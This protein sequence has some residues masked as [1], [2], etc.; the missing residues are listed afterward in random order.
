MRQKAEAQSK[1]LLLPGY[2]LPSVWRIFPLGRSPLLCYL[3][4]IRFIRICKT[5]QILQRRLLQRRRR[6]SH[7]G[8]GFNYRSKVFQR[9]IYLN[10]RPLFQAHLLTSMNWDTILRFGNY[11]TNLFCCCMTNITSVHS[12]SH[13]VR[14]IMQ[15]IVASSISAYTMSSS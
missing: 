2:G 1:G 5:P 13:S 7:P 9:L 3:C 12:F 14:A 4:K 10:Y 6:R 15:R 8:N 11:L